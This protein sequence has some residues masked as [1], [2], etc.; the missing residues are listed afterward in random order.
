[1]AC[2]YSWIVVTNMKH[3][4]ATI[5]ESNSNIVIRDSDFK[6]FVNSEIVK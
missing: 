3:T 6:F 5:L 2:P 1:M 4:P